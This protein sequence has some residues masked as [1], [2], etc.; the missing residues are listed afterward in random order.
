MY[1]FTSELNRAGSGQGQVKVKSL[2]HGPTLALLGLGQQGQ[3]LPMDSVTTRVFTAV[4]N[5]QEVR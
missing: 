3:A 5:H 4:T 2:A 1:I